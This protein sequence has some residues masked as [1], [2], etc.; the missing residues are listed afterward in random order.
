M[1]DIT[2]WSK[3]Q[4]AL[5][6]Q[7]AVSMANHWRRMMDIPEVNYP[8]PGDPREGLSLNA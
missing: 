4:N 3:E 1:D 2:R 5:S 6:W 7:R 8:Y